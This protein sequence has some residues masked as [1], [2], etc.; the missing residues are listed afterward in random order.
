MYDR[1]EA[2]KEIAE[3]VARTGLTIG[4]IQIDL[5]AAHAA[6]LELN[7]EPGP[8]PTEPEEPPPVEDVATRQPTSSPIPRALFYPGAK[9]PS[10]KLA[11]IKVPYLITQQTLLEGSDPKVDT[12]P[13]GAATCV[14]EQ[15]RGPRRYYAERWRGWV[16]RHVL[17]LINR[18]AKADKLASEYAQHETFLEH[19][20]EAF[21]VGAPGIGIDEFLHNSPGC[22]LTTITAKRSR[23]PRSCVA[24]ASLCMRG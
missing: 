4:A 19:Y 10:A 18:R 11:P 14:I 5:A 20:R 23:R 22:R 13:A 1:R 17:A 21:D 2:L 6:L 7:E 24:R 15:N 8:P 9:F 16:D 12:W 3:I